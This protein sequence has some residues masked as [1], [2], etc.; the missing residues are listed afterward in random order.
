MRT[1]DTIGLRGIRQGL[2][3]VDASYQNCR[4]TGLSIIALQEFGRI[5]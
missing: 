2:F 5:G 1:D 3:D 4:R